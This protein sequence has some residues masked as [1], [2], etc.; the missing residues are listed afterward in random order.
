MVFKNIN[1]RVALRR[2]LEVFLAALLGSGGMYLSLSES[3]EPV[4][5]VGIMLAHTPESL[6]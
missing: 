4:D 5:E 6:G 1:W 3:D 2:A